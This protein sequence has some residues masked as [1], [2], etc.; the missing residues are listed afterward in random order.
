MRYGNTGLADSLT[1]T[2]SSRTGSAIDR[3]AKARKWRTNSLK[4][5]TFLEL[6]QAQI[7]GFGGASARRSLE[8]HDR[9]RFP[10]DQGIYTEGFEMISERTTPEVH[11]Y[12][13]CA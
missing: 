11:G 8:P 5:R 4:N 9:L 6:K 12:G 1:A 10:Y 13:A 7:T 3:L 2:Q